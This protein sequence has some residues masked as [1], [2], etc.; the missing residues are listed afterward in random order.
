MLSRVTR[1]LQKSHRFPRFKKRKHTQLYFWPQKVWSLC[2]MT[3]IPCSFVKALSSFL[4]NWPI[5]ERLHQQAPMVEKLMTTGSDSSIRF[6]KAVWKEKSFFL[7]FILFQVMY[8][9]IIL[10]Q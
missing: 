6:L 10:T 4:Y 9:R 2:K 1:K 3:Y 8:F 7:H 5:L